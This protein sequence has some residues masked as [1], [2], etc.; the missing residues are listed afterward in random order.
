MRTFDNSQLNVL[1]D[2]F[3][4]PLVLTDG[5]QLTVIFESITVAIDT[6]E[7]FVETQETYLTTKK[8]LMD[9]SSTFTYQGKLQ[10]VYNIVDDLSGITN[11]YFRE[12]I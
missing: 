10:V 4:E 1:I 8:G 7:G 2:T 11:V 12:S 3:G 6:A 9:Y 5:S